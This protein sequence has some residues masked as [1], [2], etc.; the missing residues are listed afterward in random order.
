[1]TSSVGIGP[2]SEA[3]AEFG[4]SGFRARPTQP[5]K[6][7]AKVHLR[8]HR[9]AVADAKL[10]D[11]VCGRLTDWS[12]PGLLLIGDAAHPMSPVGGQG[13]NVAL[14]DALVAA[15]HL[16]PVL[17]A[18]GDASAIDAATRRIR[19]ERWAEVVTVQQMQENQGSQFFSDRRSTRFVFRL[20]PWLMRAGILPWLLRKE[21][22]LMSDG[23]VPVK[24]VV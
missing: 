6:S 11:V 13:I 21:S 18:G 14:R 5:E 17:T 12:L 2:L 8:T 22:R 4:P 16:C 20:L 24:L 10:L 19:D 23:V 3:H 7:S 15:N 1:M 9:E